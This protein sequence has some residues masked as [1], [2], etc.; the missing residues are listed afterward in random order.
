MIRGN[1]DKVIRRGE[2]LFR[3]IYFNSDLCLKNKKNIP[4]NEIEESMMTSVSAERRPEH[5]SKYPNT[6]ITSIPIIKLIIFLPGLLKVLSG[7]R[8]P[9][10]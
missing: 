4:V 6:V 8:E 7:K 2:Y 3:H 5:P 1:K 9:M 10:A